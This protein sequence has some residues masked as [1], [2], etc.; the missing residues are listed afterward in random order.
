MTPESW[1]AP[2]EVLLPDAD[3]FYVP[4]DGFDQAPP[5]TL[6]RWRPVELAAFGLIPLRARAWQ[7]LY[8]SND[9]N[10][11]PEAA[12]TT[13]I[14]PADGVADGA[15]LVSFQCAIDA[16]A[17]RAFPS[18]SLRRGSR[19]I[20]T[21][22]HVEL[23]LFAD[24]LSRGWA[25]S[26]PDHEGMLGAW[27]APREPGYRALDGVRATLAFEPGGLAPDAQVGLWGY[28]GGGLA[29]AWAAEMAPTY[30]PELDIVGAVLGSPVGDL[31]S[32]F[33][34][35][36]GGLHAGLP[37]LVVAALRRVY[38]V[39]AELVDTHFSDEGRAVLDK[40]ATS[41]TVGA[42]LRLARYSVDRHTGMPMG[43]LLALEAMLEMFADLTLGDRT[44]TA[45]LLVLQAVHDQIIAV[46]D[47]DALVE[48]YRAN[49]AHVTYLRDRLSEHL[50]LLAGSA[51]LSLNWLADRFA[52]LPVTPS[53]T[54]TVL[55]IFGLPAGRHG[56]ADLARAM[57]RVLFARPITTVVTGRELAPRTTRD[58]RAA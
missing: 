43:E 50:S 5:G 8:R 21:C 34:R 33:H 57:V 44:P 51:P 22:A 13:V 9:L 28:S 58:Q 25:V 6:L 26:V 18:Y 7:L 46:D 4:R 2:T 16:I 52:G 30:A 48:R 39:F 37:T 31:V 49:G 14:A 47:I 23:L 17:P 36:D 10:G 40:A 45:P 11:V 1:A 56:L 12:V 38:P 3:P 24:A 42:V 32:T 53:R 55:S 29:S 54:R 35:L 20:G 19:A 15:P 41:T 27:G